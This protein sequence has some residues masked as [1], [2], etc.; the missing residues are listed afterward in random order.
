M[1]VDHGAAEL[2]IAHAALELVGGSLCI[3]HGKMRETRIVVGPLLNFLGQE[4]VRC[5]GGTHGFCGVAFHLHARPGDRQDRP[6]DAVLFHHLQALL[7]E[8]GQSRVKLRRFGR[9]NVD[10]CR[11]PIGLGGRIQEMLLERDLLDHALPPQGRRPAS[12]FPF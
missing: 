4:I 12:S 1:S 2:Q 7:A 9:G 5:A 10:H 11:P 3:L 6:R 8:I